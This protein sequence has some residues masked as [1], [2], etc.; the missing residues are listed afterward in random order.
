MFTAYAD[1]G[2]NN[3]IKGIH[4]VFC[5]S[6]NYIDPT[7]H[8]LSD[9]QRND[10]SIVNKDN[11]AGVIIKNNFAPATE[12]L[13]KKPFL[14]AEHSSLQSAHDAFESVL[15][16]AGASLHRDS[17]DER[18]VKETKEGTY[19]FEGSHG[20]TN[21][22]IDRPQDVGGWGEYK[23]TEV[24]FDSDGDGMPDE[25]EIKNGLNPHDSRDGAA[26]SLNPSYTNLEVYINGLVEHLFP[27]L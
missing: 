13:V 21:G 7:C 17:H 10:I 5:F 22:M 12:V 11:S 25:W 20:S 27:G 15:K 8:R 6:G 3:N 26:Y 2:K 19:T 18:I 1:D 24:P 14:I 4:G 16:Y 9:K 23:Q